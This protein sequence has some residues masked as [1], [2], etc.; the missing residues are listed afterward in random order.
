MRQRKIALP[1]STHCLGAFSFFW[2]TRLRFFFFF[3]FVFL[4]LCVVGALRVSL[5]GRCGAGFSACASG[6]RLGL[7]AWRRCAVGPPRVWFGVLPSSWRAGVCGSAGPRGPRFSGRSAYVCRAC[8]SAAI[9]FVLPGAAV[10]SP[11]CGACGSPVCS[12]RTALGRVAG[13]DVRLPGRGSQPSLLSVRGRGPALGQGA[14]TSAT[15]PR[16]RRSAQPSWVCRTLPPPAPSPRPAGSP[17]HLESTA[18]PALTRAAASTCAAGAW[19]HA[20]PRRCALPYCPGSAALHQIPAPRRS[21]SLSARSLSSQSS[22]Y[23]ASD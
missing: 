17:L 16:W 15:P 22:T 4:V 19:T 20:P 14:V 10:Q 9:R 7:L 21:A 6:C 3:F 2:S 13:I 8:V 11:I 5:V 1:G 12:G 23:A 18:R